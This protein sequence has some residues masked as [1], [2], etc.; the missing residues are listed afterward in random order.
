[1]ESSMP[2]LDAILTEVDHFV[3]SEKSHA[4]APHIIDVILPLLCSYLPVWWS[5]GP[6]NVSL[7]AGLVFYINVISLI[8]I[9]KLLLTFISEFLL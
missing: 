1:M 3:E 5:Q 2:T 8:L 6:D 9:D 4:E 7:T